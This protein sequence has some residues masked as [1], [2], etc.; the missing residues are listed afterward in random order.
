MLLLPEVLHQVLQKFSHFK[1]L[2]H[3]LIHTGIDYFGCMF[4]G[5]VTGKR[6]YGDLLKLVIPF[7]PYPTDRIK[8]IL[9]RHVNIHDNKVELF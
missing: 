7:I 2:N 6:K 3:V 5:S 9:F 8:S 1:G 4:R